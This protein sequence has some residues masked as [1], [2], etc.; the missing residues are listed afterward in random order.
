LVEGPQEL[1]AVPVTVVLSTEQT[2]EF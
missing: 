1:L 2:L